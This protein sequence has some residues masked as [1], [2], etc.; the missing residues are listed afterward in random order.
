MLS[1]SIILGIVNWC[2]IY[3]AIGIYLMIFYLSYRTRR[4][5]HDVS[6]FLTCYTS[7]CAFLVCL[8]AFVMVTSNLFSG[9][10]LVNMTFCY[11]W[12]L[13]YDIFECSVYYSYCLQ[14]IYRLCRI[15]FYRKRYLLSY[16]LYSFLILAQCLLVL[17]VL[18]PPIFVNWYARL[19]TENYCLI[20]YTYLGPEIYHILLLYA[21][22]LICLAIVY[23]WITRYMRSVTRT[24]TLSN[25]GVNQR[26]RNQR[27]FTV[28]KR[29]LVLISILIILRFP[30]II[31]M[32]H[33]AIVGSLYSLAYPIV[34]IITSVCLILIGIITLN[35]TTQLRNE[36]MSIVNQKLNHVQPEPVRLNNVTPR[37]N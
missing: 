32:T 36:M 4:E 29:I 8:T 22:P 31:F 33:A 16:R 10:L 28:I 11:I 5:M 2:L 30:T 18:L 35:I 17:I 9:F 14:A 37:S 1:V 7:I 15:I 27:D 19:P 20:P 13:F 24:T 26:I 3:I 6:L 34:G 12:G 23:I 25:I 21:V